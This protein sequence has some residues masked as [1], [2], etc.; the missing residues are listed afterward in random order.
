MKYPLLS[1]INAPQDLRALSLADLDSLAAELRVFIQSE[2]QEKEGHIK[3]SLGVVDLSIALHYYFETPQ[4][5]LIWDVGHQAY[6]HKVLT[7][8][9]EV[10]HTNRIKDGIAGFTRRS[11]SAYDPFGAGHSSTSISALAGFC[12]A[13]LLSGENRNK[14]AVIGDGALTGGMAYEGLNYI[15]E[16]AYDCWVILNDNQSSIDDNVGALQ[17]QNS[18]IKWANALGFECLEV[19]EGNNVEAILSGLQRLSEHKGPKFLVLRTKKALGFEAKKAEISKEGGFQ[20][21]LANK[22]EDLMKA[23]PKVL[24]ISPA[25][26]AGAGLSSLREQFPERVLDVGIAEQHAVTMAAGL[27]ASGFKPVVHLYSTFAQRAIDQIIHDVALQKLAI[28]FLIDRAGLVGADG[29]THHGVFDQALLSAIP[30]IRIGTAT[31]GNALASMLEW[32]LSQGEDSIWIRYAKESVPAQSEWRS[33]RP[34]WWL[35]KG[36]KKVILSYGAM[37]HRAQEAALASDWSHLHIPIYK[38]F[39]EGDLLEQLQDCETLICIDENPFEASI[40]AK[41]KALKARA[42]IK[43]EIRSLH[44]PDQFISHAKREVLLKEYGL[45]VEGLLDLTQEF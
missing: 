14:I 17:A 16:K 1:K 31:D 42:K 36:K 23:D 39:P 11:E 19:E 45:S 7:E 12:Q 44:L 4:D 3:S 15:G 6:A 33:Y 40:G 8:R 5:I 41:M 20:D 24:V 30:N 38:P 28:T 25:M 37:A 29:P 21:S 26:L 34:H 35:N 43:A 18:Y 32:A 22:L 9:R 13:D 27:A 2:T 10:F